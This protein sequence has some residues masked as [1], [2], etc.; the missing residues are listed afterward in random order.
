MKEKILKTLK[1]LLSFRTYAGNKKDFDKLFAYVKEEYCDLVVTEYT[2]NDRKAL[3]VANTEDTNLDLVFCTH[4]DVV[5]ADSYDFREDEVNIYGRGTI[6]MKCSVAVCLNILKDIK[7]DKKIALFITGDEEIDGYSASE[8]VK[9]YNAKFAIVPDGGANFDL[10]A[11]EKGLLQLELEIDTPTAHA[12][13]PFNG[14][15]AITELVKVYEGLIKKYPLPKDASDYVTSINLSILNGGLAINQVPGHALMKL[16]IRCVNKDKKEDIINLI[17]DLNKD[18]KVKIL[19]ENDCFI[20]DLNNSFV[21][22]YINSCER[23]LNRKVNIIGC[24]S[25]SD[26]IFF[27][28]KGIPTVIMNPDGNYPHCPNEY[29]NKES[30][31]KLYDIYKDFIGEEL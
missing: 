12:A 23:V 1:D 2:F 16:D 30:L 7:T 24:E 18:V 15:N 20:T 29:V 21:K 31:V 5:N 4:I 6:D 11:E 9:L 19:F 22:R 28:E 3:V 8:L 26:A 17:H 14:V 27:C 25:T 13:Q 10:I